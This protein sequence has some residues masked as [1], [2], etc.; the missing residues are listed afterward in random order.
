MNKKLILW[1]IVAIFIVPNILAFTA[2]LEETEITAGQTLVLD[3][4]VTAGGEVND[5]YTVYWY[6]ADGTLLE[7]D[8]GIM[9]GNVGGATFETYQSTSSDVTI[10][11]N[12][13][14]DL[15]NDGI[16]SQ[17]LFNISAA[18][19]NISIIEINDAKFS[20]EAKIGQVFAADLRLRVDNKT[21]DGAHCS[22]YGT[23]INEA[24]LQTCTTGGSYSE[25]FDGRV[26][27]NGELEKG[28]FVEGETYL[29]KIRCHCKANTEE[30][31]FNEDG[32]QIG[33]AK[34]STA[35]EF[36]VTPWLASVS[37]LTDKSSYTLDD[38][39]INVCVEL[40][41]NGSRRLPVDIFYSYR[42]GTS[43]NATDR[44]LIDTYREFRGISAG[45][46]QNQCARLHI[47]NVPEIQDKTNTCYASTDVGV[48]LADP[49]NVVISYSTTSAN[50]TIISNSDFYNDDIEDDNMLIGIILGLTAIGLFFLWLGQTQTGMAL[51]I[52]SYGMTLAQVVNIAA[53]IYTYYLGGSISIILRV[54]FWI[55]FLYGMLVALIALLFLTIRF[56]NMNDEQADETPKWSEE[57]TKW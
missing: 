34:G 19:A 35:Y 26:T 36:T 27:C 37:T 11:G 38:E 52:F 14:F 55:T 7:T 31:C 23:D 29:A 17:I 13:S 6:K 20:A 24:P 41:N 22:I 42:C 47:K 32:N 49:D 3:L 44:V 45:T 57:N 50:F 43:N 56:M 46:T 12:V 5:P 21:I 9:P 8:T 15:N 53:A 40:T 48:I 28:I 4:E 51:K 25:S 33:N 39:Y 16:D 18:P 10:N 1:I 30:I 2:T 54:N